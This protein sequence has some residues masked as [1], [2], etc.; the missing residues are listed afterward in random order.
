MSTTERGR[1]AEAAVADELARRGYDIIARN[2]RTRWCE[3]DIIAR[4]DDV[5]H[6]V[7]VKYRANPAY[8]Y[9][10][11]YIGRDKQGRLIRAA[12]AWCGLHGYAGAYQ[13]D[14]VSAGVDPAHPTMEWLDSA[15]EATKS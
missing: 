11:D 9:G 4:H 2:W 15:I 6:F 12:A 5:V 7:E 3:V 1:L 8:G 13:I 14:I 10:F